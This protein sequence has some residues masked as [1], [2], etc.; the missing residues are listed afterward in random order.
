MSLGIHVDKGFPTH[1]ALRDLG[2]GGR[3]HS[4]IHLKIHS[5]GQPL[6]QEAIASP[7]SGLPGRGGIF[8]TKEQRG[9]QSQM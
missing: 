9:L 4:H 2:G 8:M 3:T 1:I 5:A 7:Q 6:R